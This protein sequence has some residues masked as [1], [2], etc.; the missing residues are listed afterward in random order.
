MFDTLC[1]CALVPRLVTRTRLHLV[2]HR[3]EARKPTNTGRL[4]ARCLENSEVW[5]RGIAGK[6]D[7]TFQPDPARI[8]V[9]L[10]PAEDAV[11]IDRFVGS[12]R[13]VTLVVPDGTWRQ[14]GKMRA[15]LPGL[16][17][18]QCVSL[19]PGPETTYGLRAETHPCGLATLEAIARALAVLEGPTVSAQLEQIFAEMVRRTRV[20]RGQSPAA[21]SPAPSSG[22]IVGG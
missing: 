19:P 3:D 9:L 5:V 22:A 18:L 16:A 1:I 20:L 14:A 4:A 8:A 21:A 7:P 6:V 13:P 10:Y 11:P 2:M 15:R 12:P 17:E